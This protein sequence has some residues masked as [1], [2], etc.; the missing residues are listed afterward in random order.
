MV[1]GVDFET[2]TFYT[3]CRMQSMYSSMTAESVSTSI[4]KFST[5]V[6]RTIECRTPNLT[7]N[8]MLPLVL[9]RTY[10]ADNS[11]TCPFLDILRN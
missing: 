8:V 11:D 4:V 2:A 1:T 9:S 5:T 10:D 3:S 6:K 7:G